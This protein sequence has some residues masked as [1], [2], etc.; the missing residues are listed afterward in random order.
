MNAAVYE[1]SVATR[2]QHGFEM[3]LLQVPVPTPRRRQEM[4][5]RNAGRLLKTLRQTALGQPI[6]LMAVC[7]R[8]ENRPNSQDPRA[9][10][11]ELLDMVACNLVADSYRP[12]CYLS[13]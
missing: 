13:D 9:E 12:A 2:S 4:S 10:Q 7:G 3:G 6:N 8:L 5:H 1:A 11:E